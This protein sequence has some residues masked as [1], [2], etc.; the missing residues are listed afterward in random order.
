MSEKIDDNRDIDIR[1]INS[2]LSLANRWDHFLKR[3][4]INR[5]KN[6][7]KPGLLALGNPNQK[8]QIFVT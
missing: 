5:S 2:Q 3:L 6:R 1:Q 4:G 7:V 8:S